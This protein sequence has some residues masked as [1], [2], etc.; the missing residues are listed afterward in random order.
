MRNR[1]N[2]LSQ[3]R[4]KREIDDGRGRRTNGEEDG[5]GG[6]GERTGEDMI[7]PGRNWANLAAVV[8]LV[9]SMMKASSDMV[10][11]MNLPYFLYWPHE[12]L[13]K[14]GYAS[15]SLPRMMISPLEPLRRVLLLV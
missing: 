6:I 5:R 4:G 3:D 2:W 13:G 14:L 10:A 11:G 12:Y 8:R 1:G 7:R 9:L 15:Q